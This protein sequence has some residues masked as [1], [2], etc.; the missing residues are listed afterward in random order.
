MA[1]TLVRLSASS[2]RSG[3]ILLI[4]LLY[5]VFAVCFGFLLFSSPQPQPKTE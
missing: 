2:Q 1:A 5:I 4:A 3:F